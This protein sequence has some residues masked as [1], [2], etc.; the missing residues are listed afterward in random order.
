MNYLVFLDA[1]HGLDTKGKRTPSFDDGSFMRENEFN[2][3]VVQKI[4]RE[5]EK[6]EN[7]EVIIVNSEKYDVSL[8]ERIRRVNTTYDNYIR[9][10]SKPKCVL[11]SVHANALNGIW[12]TQNG[13][14][15]HYYPTNM[16]DKAFSEVINK[17][18]VA[19]TG[20]KNR[21]NIGSDFQIIREPK[22]TACLCE[23][24][25]MD[26]KEEAKL[27]LTDEFRQACAEGVV[28]GLLEYFGIESMPTK[29]KVNNSPTPLYRVQVG[30]FNT[31][32]NTNRCIL[33]LQ[34][35][36]FKNIFIV[37]VDKQDEIDVNLI[38]QQS[39]VEIEKEC[40]KKY[41]DK[42][43]KFIESEV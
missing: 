19:K 22:M 6:Y 5:L 35:K 10:F 31:I 4:Y 12:G 2:R 37:N 20:L 25:F 3:I 17:H 8:D 41:K 33:D 9:K 16:I 38:T 1:G 40:I 14:S 32:E 43:I 42:I 11:I 28:N 30:A 7:V 39:H 21:G 24:A 29:D 34:V 23:C 13:T 26:N 15:T 27:L 36:G 18:L